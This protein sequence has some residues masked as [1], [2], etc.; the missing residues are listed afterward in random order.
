ME[1]LNRYGCFR[2]AAR[3]NEL[4]DQGHDIVTRDATIESGNDAKKFA[5]YFIG[6]SSS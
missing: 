1:A 2:L 6:D 5:E 3:I 4:R